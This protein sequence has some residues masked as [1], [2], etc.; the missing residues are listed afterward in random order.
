M[1]RLTTAASLLAAAIAIATGPQIATAQTQIV[2]PGAVHFASGE[3][4]A[5]AHLPDNIHLG[6]EF[7]QRQHPHQGHHDEHDD[8]HGH[9]PASPD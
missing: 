9:H 1:P 3:R 4:E 2:R 5:A 8:E 6:S 7:G